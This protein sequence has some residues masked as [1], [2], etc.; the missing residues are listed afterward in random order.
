MKSI[1]ISD[2]V[3]KEV[4][5]FLAKGAEEKTVTQFADISIAHMLILRGH[6]FSPIKKEK[7]V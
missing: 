7:K 1:K 3:H 6:K 4:K 2:S 5:I